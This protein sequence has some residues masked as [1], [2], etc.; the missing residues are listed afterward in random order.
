M[1]PTAVPQPRILPDFVGWSDPIGA[2]IG[3]I[4]LGSSVLY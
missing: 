3:F 4:H 1:D 2:S